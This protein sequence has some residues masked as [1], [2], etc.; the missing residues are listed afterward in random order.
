VLVKG[1]L[2][3]RDSRH[4]SPTSGVKGDANLLTVGRAVAMLA[5]NPMA[6]FFKS[7]RPGM[8]LKSAPGII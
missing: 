7:V 1:W 8:Q 3:N 5:G 6:D 4:Y 2:Q